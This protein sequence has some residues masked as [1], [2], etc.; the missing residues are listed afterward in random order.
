[1]N[2][3]KASMDKILANEE[4]RSYL[5]QWEL[6]LNFAGFDVTKARYQKISDHDHS[7]ALICRTHFYCADLA[8]KPV[9]EAG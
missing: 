7:M 2:V 3:E 6:D 9:L 8:M 5:Q 1:M 4:I